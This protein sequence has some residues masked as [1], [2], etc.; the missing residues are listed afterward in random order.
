M[1]NAVILHGGPSKK[2]YYDP[3]APSMSNSHWIPWLQGQ[4]LKHDIPTATPEVPWSFERDWK[5]WLGEVERFDIG[6]ETILVGHSTG[7]GFWVKYLSINKNLKV[8]KVVLV[9]P[10]LDPSRKYTKNFFDDF[11]IDPDFVKRTAGTVIFNSDND[12]EDVLE[13]VRILKEKVKDIGY[14]EFH[15]YGHFCFKDL[16]TD[17]FPELL[18]EVLAK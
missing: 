9:A 7:A 15:N 8:D 3:E 4:L 12:Q 11:E 14:R 2:E 13:T 10:W 18:G 17:K 6:P 5:V 16:K 1:K